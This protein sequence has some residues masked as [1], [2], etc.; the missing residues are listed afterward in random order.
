MNPLPMATSTGSSK[1]LSALQQNGWGLL[2]TPDNR[3]P[4]GFSLYGIDNGAWSAHTKGIPWETMRAKWQRLIE[5]H[6][7]ACLQT[8]KLIGIR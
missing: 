4:R 7:A 1:N 3:N 5:E 6:G 8:H 2:L